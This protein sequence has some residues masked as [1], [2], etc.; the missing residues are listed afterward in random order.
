MLARA[1]PL[2]AALGCAGS[3]LAQE[4]F[5][6]GVLGGEAMVTAGEAFAS[7]TGVTEGASGSVAGLQ[8]GD[9]ILAIDGARFPAHTKRVDDGGTG[10][11]RSLGEA[12]DD[13]ADREEGRT[14]VL[15]VR[16]PVDAGSEG[17]EIELQVE[18]PARPGLG[19]VRAAEARTALRRAAAAQLLRLRHERGHWDAPVGLTGDRVLTA[20][21]VV[22]LVGHGDPAHAEAIARAV[23]WLRGPD[24]LAWLPE[25]LGRG[26]D[27]L[28]NWALA[29]TSVAL[30]EH[31]HATGDAADLPVIARCNRAL[32]SRMDA[33][34]KMGHDV[35][36]GYSG[37]GFNV[38]NAM[39]Q[40]AWAAGVRV[41]VPLDEAAWQ[42]SL[43]QLA[44][45]LDPNGGVRYWTMKGTGTGDASLRSSSLCAAL[46]LTGQ[47]PELRQTL[48]AY[49][50]A[51]ASRARE[52]HAVG[53]LGM[54]VQAPALFAVDPGAYERFLAE[55]RWYL[56]LMRG[57][58]DRIT[59]I[60]GKGNNGGDSYLGFDKIAAVLALHLLA[61]GDGRLLIAG[62]GD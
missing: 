50:D 4:R 14:L 2:L 16:R 60:G 23:D 17:R 42:L 21:A 61:V 30:A 3:G 54:L 52:A 33:E 15:L 35:S 12:L 18:L 36:V 31:H 48:F 45:S 22:A 20:W 9:Q 40:L 32:A 59:Y 58:D 46:T 5:P 27:G 43:D 56:A 24:E 1:L 57:P 53:S 25:D 6:L 55:W 39:C 11:Q 49:L 37:K 7:V 29:F 47:R 62:S 44:A 28:G 51:H 8:I 13:V 34:G 38:V 41:G 19:G 26:P 10:P